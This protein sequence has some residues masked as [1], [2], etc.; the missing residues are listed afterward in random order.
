M[1]LP[2]VAVTEPY[3]AAAYA[4]R[5]NACLALAVAGAGGVFALDRGARGASD[6]ADAGVGGEWSNKARCSG[7]L[8]GN[9][10]S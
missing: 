4:N 10:P 9:G 5:K 2:L 7:S 6:G 3:A 1:V 8:L